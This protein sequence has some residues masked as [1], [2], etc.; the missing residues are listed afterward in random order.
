MMATRLLSPKCTPSIAHYLHHPA[1]LLSR[2][3]SVATD[4]G[5]APSAPGTP[6]A[7]PA[8]HHA[9][10]GAP[11]TSAS[12]PGSATSASSRSRGPSGLLDSPIMRGLSGPPSAASAGAPRVAY[13]N[14]GE[15]L[16]YISVF[17]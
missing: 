16:Y 10:A 12:T 17:K 9:A 6:V 8:A 4:I 1:V 7:P 2:Q 13:Y 15:L 11:A 5:A 14:L 3:A